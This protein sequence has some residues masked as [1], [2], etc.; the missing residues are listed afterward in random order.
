[1][2]VLERTTA[3]GVQPGAAAAA[4]SGPAS[5]FENLV[6]QGGGIR[7]FWQAGFLAG[8]SKELPLRPSRIYCVSAAA[9]MACAFAADRLEHSIECFRLAAQE[10]RRNCYPANL[11][12]RTPVFPHGAIYRRLL[13]EVFAGEALQRLKGGTDIQVLLSRPPS[14][15]P[16]VAVMPL[17]ALLYFI[18]SRASRATWERMKKWTGFESEFVS[19][20]SCATAGDLADLIL[21]S[22]CTPPVTPLYR[23]AGRPSIDGGLL[24]SVPR[25]ALRHDDRPALILM[26]QRPARPRKGRAGDVVVHPSEPITCAAWD[27]TNPMAVDA[28]VALGKRD[29]Q[30]FLRSHGL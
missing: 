6:M 7:C 27:Y 26:T 20:R 10:N 24:E 12:S 28:A 5:R 25:S 18:R 15:L 29:A 16:S 2:M 30:R 14:R 8:V 19:V 22:S 17:C 1:M 3:M 23:F 13:E 21:A 11:F 9:G 4:A